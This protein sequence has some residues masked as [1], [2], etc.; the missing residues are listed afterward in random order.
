MKTPMKQLPALTFG[1]G[2]RF[3]HQG[4]AQL[5]AVQS[6]AKRGVPLHPV[7]NKSNREHLL[8]GTTPPDLRAEADSAVKNLGWEEPYFVDADHINL[9]TVDGFIATSD[10]FTLDVADYS[11]KPAS[12]E[13]VAAFLEK[14]SGLVGTHQLPLVSEP[15]EISRED[16]E[17]TADKFLWA[18]QE[19]GR[20]YRHI[21]AA[22]SADSFVIEVSVDETDAPQTPGELLIILA[23]IADEGIPA[24]TIAPKFT[25][26]FNKG[27]DYVGDIAAFE[28]EFDA[29]LAVLAYAIRTF[30]LPDSLKI[31]VHSGSDKFSLYPIIRKLMAKHGAG[32]HLKTAG[33]TWLEEVTGLA[34][35]GG[36][37]LE[38]AKDIYAAAFPHAEALIQPYAPVVD[39]EIPKLPSIETVRAWTSQD[40]VEALN[41]DSSCPKYNREFRQFIHVAF[42]VAAGMGTRYT[43]ALKANRE[44]IGRRVHDNLLKRHIEPLFC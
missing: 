3:A 14:R 40:F 11:G 24:Q 36:E 31:S 28:R 16:L 29:D 35:S 23:M 1:M 19:A 42:K 22:K 18:M 15:L 32:L 39:I 25:G 38:I 2:D 21:A 41:H 7:W 33:T 13:A 37:G 34:E 9:H 20:I 5:S 12:P 26:R 4:E 30:G 10:F 8:V 27:V 6:A 43:D 44:I 17:R